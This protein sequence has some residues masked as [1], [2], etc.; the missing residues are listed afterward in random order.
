MVEVD[1]ALEDVDVGKW[2]HL[3]WGI[4]VFALRHVIDESNSICFENHRSRSELVRLQKY[5][6]ATRGFDPSRTGLPSRSWPP[7]AS[8]VRAGPPSPRL[9]RDSL[10]V[11]A[12]G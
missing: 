7:N 8:H 2:V 1:L 12:G 11:A 3:S 6:S 4:A 5:F 9:R 10:R